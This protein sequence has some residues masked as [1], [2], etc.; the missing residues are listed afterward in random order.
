V[1]C[2]MGRAVKGCSLGKL[3]V[4]LWMGGGCA[5]MRCYR[6]FQCPGLSDTL[7]TQYFKSVQCLK[8]GGGLP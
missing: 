4:F 3:H 7:D 2:L 6:T 5:D 1:R 8:I